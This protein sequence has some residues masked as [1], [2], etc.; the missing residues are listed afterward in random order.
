[1]ANASGWVLGWIRR[2]SWSSSWS[3][4][5]ARGGSGVRRHGKGRLGIAGSRAGEDLLLGRLGLRCLAAGAEGIGHL[6]L[7]RT[8]GIV[9]KWTC[10][11]GWWGKSE[12]FDEDLKA[13]IARGLGFRAR[14][15]LGAR[16]EFW[17]GVA[18][19]L[20]GGKT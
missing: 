11:G 15:D 12:P 14:R 3:D 2:P 8:G 1:M 20:Q 4:R 6:R 7:G 16:G 19:K 18:A 9:L 17:R 13:R 10:P 5:A